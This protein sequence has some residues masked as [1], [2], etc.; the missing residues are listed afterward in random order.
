MKFETMEDLFLGQI[1]DLYDAEQRLVKA[2]PG[3]AEA[4]VSTAR[5]AGRTGHVG[6]VDS[7]TASFSVRNVMD[8]R[9][10]LTGGM[11]CCHCSRA[12]PLNT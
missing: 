3:M 2:L 11:L 8:Q 4:T 12:R 1:Q 10:C 7:S 6:S 5:L 9:G